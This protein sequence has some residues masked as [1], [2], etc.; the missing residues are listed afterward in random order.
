MKNKQ[1]QEKAS[2]NWEVYI[3]LAQ[4]VAI[5]SPTKYEIIPY[6]SYR[7]IKKIKVGRKNE[8]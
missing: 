6:K 8:K 3:S 5:D 1:L 4:W 2:H 7:G